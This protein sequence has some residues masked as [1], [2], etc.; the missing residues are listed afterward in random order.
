[1][2]RVSGNSFY[3][4][5]STSSLQLIFNENMAPYN[6][7]KVRQALAYVIDRKPVWKVAALVAGSQSKT[8]TGAWTPTLGRT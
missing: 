2:K 6:N 5:S 4:V 3:K 7:V 8:I 1:M